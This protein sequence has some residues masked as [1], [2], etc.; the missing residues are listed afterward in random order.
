M[1]V[2]DTGCCLFKRAIVRKPGHSFVNGITTASL[3]TPDYDTALKQHQAYIHALRECSL[4]VTVLDAD[5]RYPDSTFVEDTFVLTEQCAIVA[6]PGAASRNGE[7]TAMTRAVEKYFHHVERIREPGFLDGGDV[8]RVEDHFFVGISG[9][10]NAEGA[11]QLIRILN[12]FGYTGSTVQL[13]RLLHLKTGAAYL[14]GKHILVAGELI[15]YNAFQGYHLIPVDASASLAANCIRI[16]D[17]VLMPK[18]FP[19]L[20]KTLKQKK[21]AVIEVDISEFQ[22]MDG[23]LSC[24]SLRF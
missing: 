9:R 3:G 19:G 11:G 20:K 4:E 14:G 1:C 17:Y 23:G 7:K 12:R 15:G 8:M 6:N 2:S 10:T 18:G 21:Y 22:K 16:N 13:E 5:E 24:L